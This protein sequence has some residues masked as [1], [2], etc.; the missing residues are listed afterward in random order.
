[1]KG[2]QFSPERKTYSQSLTWFQS[3][4]GVPPAEAISPNRTALDFLFR[5]T[6]LGDLNTVPPQASRFART[7]RPQRKC[8][9]ES[10]YCGLSIVVWDRG[11]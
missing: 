2:S 5:S 10:D 11:K 7:E 8:F 9:V 3:D 4:V 6:H 1:M